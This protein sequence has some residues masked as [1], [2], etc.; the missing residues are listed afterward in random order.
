MHRVTDFRRQAVRAALLIHDHLT[1]AGGR[2]LRIDPPEQ[3]WQEL[4][5]TVSRLQLAATRGWH[6]ASARLVEDLDYNLRTLDRELSALRQQLS[7]PP[8]PQQITTPREIVADLEALEQEFE[9]V[10]LDLKQHSLSVLT[11]PIELEETWL[12][13][14]RIVLGWDQISLSKA[15]EVIAAEPCAAEGDSEVTHPHVRD[16]SLCE[17]D[18]A[19]PIRAALAQ[20][21][22]LDFFTLVSQILQNYNAESAHVALDRWDGVNCR[23]CG[24]RMP[25]DEYGLCERCNVPICADCSSSC[26]GCDR[27]VCASCSGECAECSSYFCHSCLV[28]PADSERQLCETCLQN[29]HE[30]NHDSEDEPEDHPAT[31]PAIEAGITDCAASALHTVRLGEAAVPA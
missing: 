14:F 20:G 16:Q 8:R 4:R 11:K 10:T 27:F 12:G 22:L 1:G 2:V 19:A 29:Q 15:Y 3:T 9:E 7:L 25:G 23:D 30:E 31:G 5:R 26:Q 18:G 17:G 24:W 28:T 6:V 21:R 13:A